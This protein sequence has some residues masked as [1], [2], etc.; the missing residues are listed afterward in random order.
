MGVVPI[1]GLY[2][3]GAAYV[4]SQYIPQITSA[5]S[6]YTSVFHVLELR[7]MEDG[8]IMTNAS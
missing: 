2:I 5:L 4:S 1:G 3:V 6:V 8:I 7:L